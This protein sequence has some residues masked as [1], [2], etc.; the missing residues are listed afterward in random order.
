MRKL[1]VFP[2]ATLLLFSSA[3]ATED[4]GG[5]EGE[6]SGRA[7]GALNSTESSSA[8]TALLATTIGP[9]EDAAATATSGAELAAA[10]LDAVTSGVTV[11]CEITGSVSAT[12]DADS[13]TFVFDNC[14]NHCGLLAATG[15]VVVTYDI[16]SATGVSASLSTDSFRVNGVTVD[17]AVDVEYSWTSSA[18]TMAITTD[19][20]ITGPLGGVSTR[21]GS[22]SASFDEAALCITQ[23]G[24]WSTRIGLL[25]GTTRLDSYRRCALSCPDVGSRFSFEA[26]SGWSIS[27]EYTDVD[28]VSWV[29]SRGAEGTITFPR[30]CGGS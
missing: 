2:I 23:Q 25:G 30:L 11:L 4:P 18:E 1:L 14:S 10:V 3:C 22:Y 26:R 16:L 27:L 20:S 6:D 8:E 13:V 12:A 15:T 9:A 29:N 24:E 7:Q 5:D 28:E 21:Q 19:A 17:L